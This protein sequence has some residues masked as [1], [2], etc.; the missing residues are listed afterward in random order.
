[1]CV[2]STTLFKQV[3]SQLS[4]NNGAE[5]SKQSREYAQIVTNQHDKVFGEINNEA[6]N[7]FKGVVFMLAAMLLFA[8]MDGVN[9]HLSATYSFVQIL[10]IRYLL[11]V[12][13]AF[14]IAWRKGLVF[15][16]SSGRL[17]LQIVR[18]IVLVAEKASFIIAFMYLPL[19]DVHA[20][21]AVSPL[22]VTV[23]S[24]PFLGERVGFYRIFAVMTGFVGVL[25]IVRPG[26]GI[27]TNVAFIPLI[28]ALLF[29]VY[30]M[31]TRA[32][33]RRDSPET[34]L[35]YTGIVGAVMLSGLGPF[36][37][38]PPVQMDWALLLLVA[39]LGAAAH[40]CLIKALKIAAASAI[41]PFSYSLFL[42]A[43]V[44]GFIG[45]GEFPSTWTL[46][47]AAIVIASNIYVVQRIEISANS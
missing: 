38:K 21:A 10:W 11:L 4:T 46:V 14:V 3:R 20:I 45:F 32:V 18:G 25:L 47:G 2:K 13:I 15:T 6:N 36:Y 39:V 37:W 23:L 26:S 35:L 5:V 42:W 19:A 41:Q 28:A 34:S 27:M 22:I 30:Q 24:V 44:V 1:M 8:V 12:A 29:A 17:G 43:I 9:K 40:F 31:L 7:T 33:S 16:F